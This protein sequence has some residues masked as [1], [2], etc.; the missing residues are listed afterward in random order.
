MSP[1]DRSRLSVHQVLGESE[2]DSPAPRLVFRRTSLSRQ[3]NR[4]LRSA[5][6]RPTYG[7][8]TIYHVNGEIG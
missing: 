5:L 4:P 1:G 2:R 3:G 7:R 6:R 8:E